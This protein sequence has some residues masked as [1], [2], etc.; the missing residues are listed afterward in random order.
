MDERRKVLA[1]V[2]P[3]LAKDSELPP[4]PSVSDLTYEH[5]SLNLTAMA[6]EALENL[7]S[8]RGNAPATD[9]ADV[10]VASDEV[11]GDIPVSGEDTAPDRTPGNETN[12]EVQP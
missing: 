12:P 9:A 4:E 11:P 3:K 7:D 1:T 2:N 8:G 5:F 6:R 10:S